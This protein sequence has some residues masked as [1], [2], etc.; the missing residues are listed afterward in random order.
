[1]FTLLAGDVWRPGHM[2]IQAATMQDSVLLTFLQ[3]WEDGK[4]LR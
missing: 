1:M 4:H 2:E 3:F